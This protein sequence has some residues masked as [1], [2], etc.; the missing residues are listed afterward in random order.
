VRLPR[1]GW[2]SLDVVL[3]MA[4]L[5]CERMVRHIHY[6]TNFFRELFRLPVDLHSHTRGGDAERVEGDH[7]RQLLEMFVSTTAEVRGLSRPSSNDL[8]VPALEDVNGSRSAN[9]HAGVAGL[10][11]TISKCPS[12][13]RA[14]DPER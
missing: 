12:T 14:R 7:S 13:C 9:D 2:C 1:I 6:R 8:G 11:P 5:G 10:L 3:E 4:H